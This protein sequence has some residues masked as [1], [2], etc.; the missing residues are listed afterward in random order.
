[1]LA[2]KYEEQLEEK[3]FLACKQGKLV[4]NVCLMASSFFH[5][6]KPLVIGMINWF[7]GEGRLVCIEENRGNSRKCLFNCK[8]ILSLNSKIL[9][10]GMMHRLGLASVTSVVQLELAELND[11]H[12]EKIEFFMLKYA[13]TRSPFYSV[14]NNKKSFLLLVSAL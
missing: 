9:L 11:F 12:L 7:R 8:L 6:Q 10:L 4:E 13:I 14:R 2:L 1:M 3:A 5:W